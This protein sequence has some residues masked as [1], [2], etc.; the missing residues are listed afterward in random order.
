MLMGRIRLSILAK[1]ESSLI[2]QSGEHD[3]RRQ[4]PNNWEIPKCCIKYVSDVDN[5]S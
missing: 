5:S 2:G 4:F 1:K 3:Y